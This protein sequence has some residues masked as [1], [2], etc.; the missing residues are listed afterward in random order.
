MAETGVAHFSSHRTLYYLLSLL[1]YL[2][3]AGWQQLHMKSLRIQ[4]VEVVQKKK[5][6]REKK[7]PVQTHSSPEE[8][9]VFQA[10][11]EDIRAA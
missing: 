8:I 5:K 1:T 11:F 10:R 2:H 3:K 6:V 7:P 4:A 9:S